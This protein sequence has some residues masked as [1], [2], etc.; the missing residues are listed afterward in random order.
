MDRKDIQI[1]RLIELGNSLDGI[2]RELKAMLDAP[3]PNHKRR[4]NLK[5]ERMAHFSNLLD[6]RAKNKKIPK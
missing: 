5:A 1:Q 3:E 2:I 4:R 6:A